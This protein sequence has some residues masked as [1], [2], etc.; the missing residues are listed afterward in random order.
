[1]ALSVMLVMVEDL[2]VVFGEVESPSE[3]TPSE[4]T[5]MDFESLSECVDVSVDLW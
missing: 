2:G 5:P 1:M 4:V 3:V